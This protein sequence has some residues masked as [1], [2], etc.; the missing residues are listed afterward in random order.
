MNLISCNKCGTVLDGGKL[1]FP[2]YIFN[3]DGSVDNDA[4]GWNGNDHVPKVKCPV[5]QGDI[6]YDD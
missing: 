4:A 2:D 5:C 1:N 6:L 3:E